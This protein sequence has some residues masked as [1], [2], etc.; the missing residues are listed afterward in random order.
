VKTTANSKS[1][2]PIAKEIPKPNFLIGDDV[3]E[4]GG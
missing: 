1:Q 3:L 4:L 2:A